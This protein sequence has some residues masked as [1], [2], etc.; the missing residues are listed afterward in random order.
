MRYIIPKPTSRLIRRV[1]QFTDWSVAPRL[2]LLILPATVIIAVAAAWIGFA[3]SSATLKDAISSVPLV[4]AKVQANTMT[5][6]LARMQSALFSIAQS[7]NLSRNVSPETLSAYFHQDIDIISE[8]GVFSRSPDSFVMFRDGREFREIPLN[9]IA[10]D[11]YSSVY[12]ILD[13]PITP[14]QSLIFPVVQTDIPRADLGDE[15]RTGQNSHRITVMR[16]AIREIETEATYFV[17]INIQ[18]MADSLGAMLKP[19]APLATPQ[20]ANAQQL[21]FFFDSGGWI[22]FEMSNNL[23][24]RDYFPDHTRRGFTGDLGRPGVDAVF[25]PGAEYTLYWSMVMAVTHGN[26]DKVEGFK[27][28]ELLSYASD[29]PS[30]CYAPV[31]LSLVPDE[32]PHPI[33]GIAFFETS[34]LP[35]MA[36]FKIA[37]YS[38]AIA[39]GVIALFGL[40]VWMIGRKIGRPFLKMSI[41]IRDMLRS[42]DFHS[43]ELS[44]SCEEHHRV[45]AAMNS[46]LAR[47]TTLSAELELVQNEM[48]RARSV[49]PLE[50]GQEFVNSTFEEKYGL[51]GSTPYIRELRAQVEKA[52]RAGTDVLIFGE[53]GTGKE[54]VANAIHRASARASGPF[55]SINCGAL[56]ENLL[57]D[58]LF[59]HVKGA[60]TEAKSDRKGAF[61]AADRGTLFLDEI[62]TASP[63][64][65]QALLR[66]L[67]IRRVTPLGSD[68]DLPVNVRVVAA[69]NADLLE[70]SRQ[71]A[72]RED[73][74]YRLAIITIKTPPLRQHM[75]DIPEL[76]AFFI[77]EAATHL[78]RAPARL[79]RG[80]LDVLN[81]HSWPGNIRELRNCIMRIMAFTDGDLILAQHI[82]IEHGAFFSLDDLR[83]EEPGEKKEPDTGPSEKVGWE[84]LPAD[85]IWGGAKRARR[86]EP[87]APL[88]APPQEAP[89]STLSSAFPASSGPQASIGTS[90]P[91]ASVRAARS[92]NGA[93]ATAGQKPVEDTPKPSSGEAAKTLEPPAHTAAA[94]ASG[95]RKG[96]KNEGPAAPELG[97]A[98]FGN[99]GYAVP[100]E[101]HQPEFPDK[102]PATTKFEYGLPSDLNT[103]QRKALGMINL[104]GGITRSQFQQIAGHEVSQRTLQNDLRQLVQWGLLEKRGAG[105]ATYYMLKKTGKNEGTT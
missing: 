88:S 104:Q 41:D 4:E 47:A 78:K 73:L 13:R 14:G 66:T 93:E 70:L 60:F 77:Q 98:A 40:W 82:A 64:V 33:G 94:S 92:E 11:P 86:E 5:A 89:A 75:Q 52:A 48:K 76:A 67:S 15:P 28:P 7:G 57:L 51:V 62:G 21:S 1:G 38:V 6:Q 36:F 95:P 83:K 37:N 39:C 65:Q 97:R 42:G 102:A 8:I 53:T 23:G 84:T 56:D 81:A 35:A 91:P 34:A 101:L 50:F 58:A 49:Q 17:G 45:Q 72:F 31:L 74:Y 26:A 10:H 96:Q 79:T 99:G 9:A 61:L 22:I 105:P 18:K 59:G 103:R 71:N 63:K 12:Q 87:S 90:P 46:V 69:S 32:D 29:S 2:L 30:L 44:Q 68:V 55:I 16:M 20:E 54:I 100:A 27:A 80:G 43:V 85:F 24:K 3:S 19:G 25:R